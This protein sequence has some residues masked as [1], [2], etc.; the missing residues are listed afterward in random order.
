[1]GIGGR[2]AT[3]G[4]TARLACAVIVVAASIACL[5]PSSARASVP[6]TT[7]TTNGHCYGILGWYNTAVM[8]GGLA[9][10]RTDRLSVPNP[11]S[12]IAT[13]EIWM[14]SNNALDLILWT[15]E[16]ATVGPINGTN[17]GFTWF[18]ADSRPAGGYH[19]HYPGISISYGSTYTAKI[20]YSGNDV[21]GI[22]KDGNWIANS[23][24]QP[25]CAR[26]M[27]AGLESNDNAGHAGGYVSG[28][29]KKDANNV[30]SYNWYGGLQ[31][32]SP[33]T[34]SW[35]QQYASFNYSMN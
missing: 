12:E 26:S 13:S 1:M 7:N 18:W 14:A 8:H 33:A 22:Y 25:C 15:E 10:I 31:A 28:L 6:C 11:N 21:W 29:Q 9:Y 19:E 20:T 32:D 2:G 17:H 4:R 5:A 3:R 35:S 27:A 16:G 24:G 23:T 34:V 30:W